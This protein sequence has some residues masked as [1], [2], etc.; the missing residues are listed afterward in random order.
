MRHLFI[1]LRLTLKRLFELKPEYFSWACEDPLNPSLK[2]FFVLAGDADVGNRSSAILNGRSGT[3]FRRGCGRSAS[4]E[5][6]TN[7]I[8]PRGVGAAFLTFIHSPRRMYTT[9]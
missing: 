2:L 5:P 8:T 4:K 3:C 6:C 9:T 1:F 7:D